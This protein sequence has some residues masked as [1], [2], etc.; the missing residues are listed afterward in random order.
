[1]QLVHKACVGAITGDWSD[2]RNVFQQATRVAVAP[3]IGPMIPESRFTAWDPF[4]GE[5]AINYYLTL[6]ILSGGQR[7]SGNLR[8]LC[9][10]S[11]PGGDYCPPGAPTLIYEEG[12]FVDIDQSLEKNFF[13]TDEHAKY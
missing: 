2:L 9:D 8:I 5:A 3:V 6:G 7:V 13:Y 11:K 4:T 10:K 1:M 12:I